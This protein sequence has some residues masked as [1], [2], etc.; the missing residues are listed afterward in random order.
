[1]PALFDPIAGLGPVALAV[2]LAGLAAG[3]L[4]RGYAGFGFSALLVASWSL[5]GTPVR[6]VA[7]ALVL[8]VTAS[9]IQAVSVWRDISWRRVGLLIAGA[10]VG[11]PLGVHLLAVTDERTL[12]LVIAGF[13]LVAATAL[14]TG[15][16]FRGRSTPP[17][18]LAVGVASGACNG[19]VALGGLPVAIFL[20]AEGASPRSIRASVVAYFF[21]LDVVGLLFLTRAGLVQTQTFSLA[22]LCLPVLVVGMWLGSRHFLGATPEGFRRIT[23]GLLVALALIGIVRTLV[24][25]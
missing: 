7:V 25:R 23:L 9:V 1:M 19:A 21:L 18:V 20:T 4:A 15:L 10:A 13:I 24:L 6:A 11:T 17:T 3:A 2:M 12:R 16:K 5:V 14:L 22:L 8:E